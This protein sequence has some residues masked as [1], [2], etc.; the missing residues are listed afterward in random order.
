MNDKQKKRE[1]RKAKKAAYLQLKK[2]APVSSLSQDEK[3]KLIEI[4][5]EHGKQ[6]NWSLEE[7]CMVETPPSDYED[8]DMELLESDI[9]FIGRSLGNLDFDGW[10]FAILADKGG[11]K[12]AATI[13]SKLGKNPNNCRYVSMKL[14]PNIMFQNL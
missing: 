8:Y 13:F 1:K 6:W 14:N 10:L 3:L 7:D 4:V 5:N 9:S 2:S 11:S 12:W